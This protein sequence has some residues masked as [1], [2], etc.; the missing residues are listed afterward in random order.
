MK[1]E[2]MDDT[3]NNKIVSHLRYCK[4]LYK[5]SCWWPENT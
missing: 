5:E 1:Y 4:S 2:Q 3:T